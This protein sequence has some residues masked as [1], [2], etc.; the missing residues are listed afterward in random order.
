MTFC[1]EENVLLRGDNVVSEYA[2][3]III[4]QQI[5]TETIDECVGSQDIMF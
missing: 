5:V 4:L 1:V 3:L 2:Y